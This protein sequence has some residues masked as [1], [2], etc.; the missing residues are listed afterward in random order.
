MHSPYNK[1]S[2][3]ERASK[4]VTACEN[5]QK[6]I[7]KKR[8][9]LKKIEDDIMDL[10]WTVAAILVVLWLFGLIGGFGGALIHLLLVIAAIVVLIRLI[11]GKN[12]ATGK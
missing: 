2:S 12:L 5:L 8:R 6:E 4:I 9:T 10:F 7:F 11:Q 3:Q 1:A